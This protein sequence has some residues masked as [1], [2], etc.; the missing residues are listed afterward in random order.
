MMEAQSV[1]H[2]VVRNPAKDVPGSPLAAFV[3]L[4]TDSRIYG[5]ADGDQGFAELESPSATRASSMSAGSPSG[6]Q[7]IQSLPSRM[8]SP[9]PLGMRS[10]AG[11]A[12]LDARDQY[13]RN[14][15]VNSTGSAT[16]A[17]TAEPISKFSVDSSTHAADMAPMRQSCP[18]V[19]SE[20][21]PIQSVASPAA[22]GDVSHSL[23]TKHSVPLSHRGSGI[24][25]ESTSA[26]GEVARATSPT[27]RP[28]MGARSSQGAIRRNSSSVASL[29]A[30]DGNSSVMLAN[31][32]SFSPRQQH[33]P[34]A[35]SRRHSCDGLWYHD[36]YPSSR[37]PSSRRSS[38]LLF[39]SSDNGELLSEPGFRAN[40]EAFGKERIRVAAQLWEID[41]DEI[42]LSKR[43]GEGSFGEVL[44]GQFRGT[45][46]RAA[47]AAAVSH[48]WRLPNR[49]K[50][51]R[52]TG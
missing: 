5:F 14:N 34:P 18:E 19:A 16:A 40:C 4:V 9:S 1:R 51:T 3:G 11:N 49:G 12:K 28:L 26:A 21:R 36:G 2:L 23:A 43:I 30:H 44:L 31:Q 52:E 6:V 25:T 27:I 35:R 46:V 7:R 22:S 42:Q 32:P 24:S 50:R 38:M 33:A 8:V 48:L 41:F 13:A 45:K 39:G 10:N 17:L 20:P 29:P 37:Q 47:A 15:M